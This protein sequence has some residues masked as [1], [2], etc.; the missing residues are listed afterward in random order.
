MVLSVL[1]GQF[2]SLVQVSSVT[3]IVFH[4]VF[5][6]TFISTFINNFVFFIFEFGTGKDVLFEV[7]GFVQSQIFGLLP[8]K[9]KR[10]SVVSASCIS[11]DLDVEWRRHLDQWVFQNISL[12]VHVV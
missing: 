1:L 4:K 12:T 9:N 8:I 7:L 2:V 3:H 5:I 6:S 11:L 10:N